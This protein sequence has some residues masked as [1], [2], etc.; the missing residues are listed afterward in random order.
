MGSNKNESSDDINK[1]RRFKI[2]IHK[3]HSVFI[4]FYQFLSQITS[5]TNNANKVFL[6]TFKHLKKIIFPLFFRFK[7]I[8]AT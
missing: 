1:Q 2:Q 4:E 6:R 5:F 3:M 8:K 7:S